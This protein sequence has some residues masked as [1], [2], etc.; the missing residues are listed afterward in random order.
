MGANVFMSY[1]LADQAFAR[2]VAGSLVTDGIEA[3]MIDGVVG[4]GEDFG[5][6]LRSALNRSDAV[7]TVLSRTA[8]NSLSVMSELGAAMAL[9]KRVVLVR[10]DDEPL[11]FS[12]SHIAVLDAVGMSPDEIAAAVR[13]QLQTAHS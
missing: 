7:V 11:P 4:C 10:L 2:Q 3:V 13:V 5:E 8:S 9:N 12:A 6:G 1:S